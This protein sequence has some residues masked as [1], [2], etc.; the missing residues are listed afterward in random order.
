MF[1]ISNKVPSCAVTLGPQSREIG[2]RSFISSIQADQTR[3]LT[4]QNK[5]IVSEL[6][7]INNLTEFSKQERNQP[8][9]P[10]MF[11]QIPKTTLINSRRHCSLGGKLKIFRLPPF[12]LIRDFGKHNT[13]GNVSKISVN[14]TCYRH[15]G[16]KSTNHSPLA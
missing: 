9:E 6:I 15:V 13:R 12:S 14:H 10:Q 5:E 1:K 8:S 11:H 4:H 3:L 2:F 7:I 16:S